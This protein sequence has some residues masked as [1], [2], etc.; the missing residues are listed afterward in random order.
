MNRSFD[1]KVH[2]RQRI[3]ILPVLF[4][5]TACASSD[6][7]PDGFAIS[8]EN[9]IEVAVTSGGPRYSEELFSYEQIVTLNQNDGR[10]ESLIGRPYGDEHI[11]EDGNIYII[12]RAPNRIA[13]FD[14]AGNFSHNIGRGGQGPGEFNPG[15]ALISVR[16]GVV[17]VF[18]NNLGR[19]STFSTD[20]TFLESATITNTRRRFSIDSFFRLSDDRMVTIEGISRGRPG[21][22][23][24]TYKTLTIHDAAADTIAH[25]ITD[26]VMGSYTMTGGG[27]A[28]RFFGGYPDIEFHPLHGIFVTTGEEPVIRVHDLDGVL[29][30]VIRLDI[31][32]ESVTE[33]ERA[34]FRHSINR[35]NDGAYKDD[36]RSRLPHVTYCN[37]K[38][39]WDEIVVEENGFIWAGYPGYTHQ[40]ITRS[41]AVD[42][43]YRIFSPEGEYL[44]DTTL[45]YRGSISRGHLIT[46]KRND[47]TEELYYFIF[48]IRPAVEGLEY[49]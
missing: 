35:L 45:P 8:R 18:D 21:E 25:L 34:A 37:P 44:G 22:H 7:T 31:E 17:T 19:V 33:E 46:L 24:S 41:G 28:Y 20:G 16:D 38:A 39:W 42:Y 49:P 6:T 48:R 5:L 32:P 12:D 15:P 36:M 9:G 40:T 27:I 47:E 4:F 43:R 10:E 11:D 26:T 13:C 29:N 3:P 2:N 1:I 30:R 23:S 14:A